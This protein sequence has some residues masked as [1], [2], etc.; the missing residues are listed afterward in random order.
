MIAPA[1]SAQYSL[2]RS[3]GRQNAME[4]KYRSSSGLH[5][6]GR[7]RLSLR[8]TLLR[9]IGRTPG[10]TGA[11]GASRRK[12]AICSADP[13]TSAREWRS[14]LATI[15]KDTRVERYETG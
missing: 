5:E 3:K 7:S 4:S 9:C 2:V 13:L 1:N 8:D 10:N 6:P 15:A 14:H 12:A 11:D